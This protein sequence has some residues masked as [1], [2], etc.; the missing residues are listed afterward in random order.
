MSAEKIINKYIKLVSEGKSV[1]SIEEIISESLDT[2]IDIPL[3]YRIPLEVIVRIVSKDDIILD[4]H[5]A[6]KLIKNC[7]R[8]HGK[9][10]IMLLTELKI[11]DVST[12]D[13]KQILGPL[14]VCPILGKL[15]S[16]D[17]YRIHSVKSISASI[18]SSTPPPGVT[19][20]K[21]HNVNDSKLLRPLSPSIS[22]VTKTR[23]YYSAPSPKSYSLPSHMDY[24]KNSQTDKKN[25]DNSRGNSPKLLS[26]ETKSDRFFTSSTNKKRSTSST[27]NYKSRHLKKSYSSSSSK[28]NNKRLIP[29]KQSPRYY[30]ESHKSY[31]SKSCNSSENPRRL[32]HK[33][34]EYNEEE[35]YSSEDVCVRPIKKLHSFLVEDNSNDEVTETRRS[36]DS[37]KFVK[38]VKKK[39][40]AKANNHATN[41]STTTNNRDFIQKD[42][43]NGP[44]KRCSG[45]I[46]TE[47]NVHRAS[48]EGNLTELI[49]LLKA[50]PAL[51]NKRDW[52]NQTPLHV[53]A[54]F[55]K[56]G[57]AEYLVA[58][59]ADLESREFVG[60]TPLH[61]AASWGQDEVAEFLVRSGAQIEARTDCGMT[62]LAKA[63]EYCKPSTVQLLCNLG[64]DVDATD[65]SG[66]SV[67]QNTDD[68]EIK[69]IILSVKNKKT[70][71]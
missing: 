46:F 43:Y 33:N 14:L 22:P 55:G 24:Y 27:S 68:N 49:K 20:P 12:E 57:I 10:A 45:S 35:Y 64:A 19:K 34:K 28:E 13:L 53:A 47:S 41:T 66:K 52:K 62:P 18:N 44:V 21:Q 58:S 71:P 56:L 6:S 15:F 3:F 23:S 7:F 48:R 38:I 31:N 65:L 9:N 11:C 67:V 8:I 39:N 40:E 2:Y 1:S 17:S 36:P 25:K 59:G 61:F 26:S 16:K 69:Q 30:H 29:R 51:L 70:A 54:Q 32:E 63:A 50:D 60:W 4:A 37:E 42:V 5:A